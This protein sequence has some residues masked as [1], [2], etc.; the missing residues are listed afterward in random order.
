[1]I[2]S[3]KY[4]FVAI[5]LVLISSIANAEIFSWKA[6]LQNVGVGYGATATQ[7]CINIMDIAISQG[8]KYKFVRYRANNESNG[9]CL[10]VCTHAHCT[11][12]AP[13]PYTAD[14]SGT[15]C[16]T[17]TTYNLTK[18]EC[19][20]DREK[21][22]PPAIGCVGNPISL[23]V[24]NK[25]QVVNDGLPGLSFIRFY[26]SLDGIWRHEYSTSIRLSAGTT[27]ALIRKDGRESL[28]T[29]QTTAQGT[30]VTPPPTELGKISKTMSGWELLDTDNT[31]YT[32]NSDGKLTRQESSSGSY[33]NLSYLGSTVT[34]TDE[35]GNQLVFTEDQSNQ[36][37]TLTQGDF[38]ITYSYGP[39]GLLQQ[40][41]KTESGKSSNLTYHYEDTRS[42]KLLTGITDENGVRHATWSYDEMGR[43]VSSEHNNGAEIV[44]VVYNADSSATV[45]NG[46][47]KKTVYRFQTI[48]DVKRVTAIE[49]EPSTNCPYSNS[50][51]T[52]DAKGL[53]KTKIDAKGSV[54]TFDYNTR[55]LETSRTEAAG[56]LQARA[57]TTEWHPTLF[58]KVK[59]TEPDR[60]ITYQYDAMGRL[61]NH[62]VTQH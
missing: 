18:G 49:G 10:Y 7:A 53:L 15:T 33:R 20:N 34:V 2:N 45:T 26:N 58:L 29:L 9:S 17:G 61:T 1:M 6:T 4:G 62:I 30:V 14:R 23:A 13:Y 59:I 25:F 52:Y 5:F 8:Y 28:F 31:R 54:T 37:L 3:N 24:G 16:P 60:I 57:I 36:P 11:G 39:S 51:F 21:G 56:S 48:Q 19:G 22:T 35:K 41:T 32:F 55:G 27:H 50:T 38:Q 40:V 43:A 47:G 12:Q 42:T 44:T 46:Y